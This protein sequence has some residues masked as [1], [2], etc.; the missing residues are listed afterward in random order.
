[1]LPSIAIEDPDLLELPLRTIPSSRDAEVDETASHGGHSLPILQVRRLYAWMQPHM[2]CW[3]PI[4]KIELPAIHHANFAILWKYAL[5]VIS[6]A[7]AD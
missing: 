4:H 3:H 7:P 6:Q 1:M 5:E 2:A